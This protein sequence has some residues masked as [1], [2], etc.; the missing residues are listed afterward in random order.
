MVGLVGIIGKSRMYGMCTLHGPA[1]QATHQMVNRLSEVAIELHTIIDLQWILWD[2]RD[3]L[4]REG[5]GMNLYIVYTL[6]V[7]H[8]SLFRKSSC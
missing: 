8:S 3:G 6:Y 5:V 7:K 4:S 1:I 2:E